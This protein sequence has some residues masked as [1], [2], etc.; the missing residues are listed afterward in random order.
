MNN[1]KFKAEI[2]RNK[3]EYFILAV[4]LLFSA[5]FRLYRL[6]KLLGFWYDQGRDA[7][8]IWDFLHY[9]KFFLIGPVTGIE[10]IF[11][12][13]FYY[14]LLAPFYWLG[15]G[16][17]VLAAAGQAWLAVGAVFLIYYLG[18]KIFGREAGL[19][20]ALLY[21]FSY[22]QV[23]FA[24]WLAN[25][26]PLPFFTLILLLLLYGFFQGKEKNLI[27]AGFVL[28]LCLQL[29]AAAAT[30]FLPA[31][32]V[33]LLWQRKKI[34]NFRILFLS[35]LAFLATLL[36][37]IYFNFR[38]DG[39]L[40]AAFRKFLLEEKSFA[41]AGGGEI[42]KSRLLLYF[43]VF[44]SKLFPVGVGGRIALLALFSATVF[45]FRKKL[46]TVGGKFLA[47]WLGVPLVGYFF[48]RG[49]NGYIWDYYFSGLIPAFLII[50]SA[51]IWE[52][53]KRLWV[54]KAV[55]GLFLILFLLM[56]TRLIKNYLN[57]GIGIALR[58]QIR[59]IDWIYNDVGSQEFNV[60]TYVPPQISFSYSYLFRWYGGS[61]YGREPATK[62]VKNL[63]TLEE[64][65]GEHPQL[66]TNWLK[67]QD[68][69]GKIIKDYS[70]GDISVQRRERISP[71]E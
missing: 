56:N 30:F 57:S 27:F 7:L 53:A 50:F 64:P 67:R 49:N 38:H 48:Y 10:G 4:I 29:E 62:L 3:K 58:S 36:P 51:V 8:V 70:W 52:L 44:F 9:H 39:I 11:L 60:D 2:L 41:A 45:S 40:L 42:L 71:Y 61:R 43:D 65:D 14:Y 20:A 37:Q 23:V 22:Q 15:K 24:R 31:I 21:G 35:C 34:K 54:G 17:P 63:Y 33:L 19:L 1:S 32:A 28:G 6:D 26:S 68:N 55:A 5:F 69:L 13:P 59:A 66:L 47:L 18:K 16:S 46:F 25:P 12:G